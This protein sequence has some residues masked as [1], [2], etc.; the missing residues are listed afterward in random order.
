MKN[1]SVPRNI[2]AENAVIS[3][4]LLNKASLGNVRDYLRP[5]DFFSSE[6]RTL[7]IEML[8]CIDLGLVSNH[9][10]RGNFPVDVLS[11]EL[12]KKGLLEQA[13]GL[14]H[15]ADLIENAS[16]SAAI[17]YHA[18]QVRR[19]A[20]RRRLVDL[21]EETNEI[22]FQNGLE[23]IFED[24]KSLRNRKHEPLTR[25][26]TSCETFFE[27]PP[28]IEYLFE[29]ILP[30][31]IVGG[32]V[33]AGGVS[34]T[35][36]ELTLCVSMA[37]GQPVLKH[38]KPTNPIQVLGLF[39]EDPESILHRRV[40][41]IIQN[42]F[43]DLESQTRELLI[44]NFHLKSV[45]GQIGPLMKLEGSNPV[46]SDHYFWLRETVEQHK[47]EV[48]ILD[49]KSRFYGLD[50][51]SNDHNTAWV[52]CLE[53]LV[54]DYGLT[55][56]F[57]H[58]VSKQSGG[59]LL[60]T[61][62]RGGSALV[63]AC[64]WVANLKTMDEVTA[65]KYEVDNHKAFIEFDV[66]KNN[67]APN[68]PNTIYLKRSKNGV[69]IPVNLEFQRLKEMADE[70]CTILQEERGEGRTYTEREITYHAN[71]KEVRERLKE[72]TGC[73]RRELPE[74]ISFATKEGRIKVESLTGAGRQSKG[75]LFPEQSR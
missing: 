65:N 14:G 30:K 4:I 58:H 20:I 48:L 70:L 74:V 3:S 45:M 40:W 63:D 27:D 61:S 13:G 44:R 17:A 35:F 23:S 10:D 56:I 39:A 21:S 57:S 53:E 31:G 49:P 42:L 24:I 15:L 8:N 34:K 67:Y 11:T 16:T 71:G 38:F 32:I 41:S 2:N 19:T 54:H 18:Q 25:V 64:R 29:G 60:Q 28:E 52:S 5:E 1:G 66:T 55:V 7:F 51:N 68:L 37:T 36:F 9:G 22:D 26:E 33:G 12:E 47:C 59:A 6:N 46:P 75:I 72:T 73:T 62:A 43:P 69:L 50:E